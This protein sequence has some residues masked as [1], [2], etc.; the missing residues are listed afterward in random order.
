MPTLILPKP[1]GQQPAAR[2]RVEALAEVLCAA[3]W[4]V[5]LTPALYHLPDDSPL[6]ERLAA[7]DTAVALG[8]LHPRAL[9]WLLRRR[10][11]NCDGWQ[12]LNLDAYASADEVIA[13]VGSPAD[14][15]GGR[16]TFAG[17]PGPRWYPVAD[18]SR[19]SNCGHCLQFCLFG[20]YALDAAGQVQVTNPDACK[21][22]CPA[23]SRVCPSSAIMFPRYDDP[24][25]AGAPGQFLE[26]DAEARRMF[27]TRTER[28]CPLCA[29]KTD[30]EIASLTADGCCPECG[31]E[32][33]AVAPEPSATLDE[34]DALI[35]RLDDLHGA[36]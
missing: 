6:W 11:V 2:R 36:R 15:E 10:G 16:E 26:R 20:V 31:R 33:D 18:L 1:D 14:A 25:I 3:G 9:E 35:G 17:E 24:A 12:L 29:A 23:C 13:A 30:T 7:L 22:G 27:Y 19:C 28:P 8:W 5:L 34:I 32:L 4:Q 21:D